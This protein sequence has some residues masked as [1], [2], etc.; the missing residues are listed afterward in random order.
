MHILEFAPCHLPIGFVRAYDAV[1]REA[2]RNAM[3]RRVA[4]IPISTASLRDIRSI[5]AICVHEQWSTEPAPLAVGLRQCCSLSH[6]LS[7]VHERLGNRSAGA[8]GQG[9]EPE[10][11]TLRL[12]AWAGELYLFAT[13]MFHMS[14]MI[15]MVWDPAIA[16]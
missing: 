15:A 9:L 4:P 14:K 2:V 16:P 13:N 12:L 5:E 11:I 3:Y 8:P 1:R 10:G 6:F 7:V